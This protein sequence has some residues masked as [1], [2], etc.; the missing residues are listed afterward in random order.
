MYSKNSRLFI[1]LIVVFCALTGCGST[2]SPSVNPIP[3]RTGGATQTGVPNPYPPNIGTLAMNDPLK[4]NSKGYN[5]DVT[6]ISSGSC[7][8]SGGAYHIKT[9]TEAAL[10]C[11]PEAK[12]LVLSNFTYEVTLKNIQGNIEGIAFRFNQQTVT[13]YTFFIDTQKRSYVLTTID[14]SGGAKILAGSSTAIVTGLN[15]PNIL[16]VT[17][18]GSAMNLYINHQLVDTATNSAYSQGQLGI[19]AALADIEASNARAWVF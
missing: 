12:S 10:T 16:A 5:W 9:A 13:G 18:N 8:F 14:G 2:S 11:N 6:A 1:L 7:G 4:D 17:A 15:K 19:F 3:T